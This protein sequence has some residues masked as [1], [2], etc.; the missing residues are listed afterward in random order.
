MLH[1][2]PF[3]ICIYTYTES[4]ELRMLRF[5][6]IKNKIICYPLQ[7]SKYMLLYIGLTVSINLCSTQVGSVGLL[8]I[9]CVIS[10]AG[11]GA[12]EEC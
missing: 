6:S 7:T 4:A 2:G 10:V 8:E 5:F 12:F 9:G 11:M 3:I 1:A